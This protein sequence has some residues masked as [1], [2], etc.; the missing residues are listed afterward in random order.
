M[1]LTAEI[2]PIHLLKLWRNIKRKNTQNNIQNQSKD[3][4]HCLSPSPRP[5]TRLNSRTST[6][7]FR[8]S[9]QEELRS[10]RRRTEAQVNQLQQNLLKQREIRMHT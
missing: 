5:G 2:F 1:K 6:R 7:P 3:R 9:S 4:T 10:R 8:R